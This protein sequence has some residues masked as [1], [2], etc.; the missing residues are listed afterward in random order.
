MDKAQRNNILSPLGNQVVRHHASIYVDDVIIFLKPELHDF[1]I[2]TE[3]L[4]IF[5]EA[6][7]LIIDMSKSKILPIRCDGLN[8]TPL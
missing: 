6:S 2:V 8:L 5:G 1:D 3:V 7:G 4:K